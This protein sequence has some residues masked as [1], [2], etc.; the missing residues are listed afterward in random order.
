MMAMHEREK[1]SAIITMK[2][3]PSLK[4]KAE[5]KAEEQGRSLSNYIESL[6]RAD[7]DKS[8]SWK[9]RAVARTMSIDIRNATAPLFSLVLVFLCI[10]FHEPLNIAGH[11]AAFFFSS[12]F[13]QGFQLRFDPDVQRGWFCSILFWHGDAPFF[14]SSASFCFLLILSSPYY[15]SILS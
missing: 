12:F 1:R 15:V 2:V 6:I 14:S 13:D 9:K 4:A 11:R 7:V 8:N 3:Q 10:L 5:A